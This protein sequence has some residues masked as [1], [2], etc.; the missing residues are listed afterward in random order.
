M[1][2]SQGPRQYAAWPASSH[3]PASLPAPPTPLFHHSDLE[4][5]AR[6]TQDT[7]RELAVKKSSA[8]P[9]FEPDL[10]IED[11]RRSL[12]TVSFS[13]PQKGQDAGLGQQEV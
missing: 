10:H 7:L 2:S 6:R 4:A 13:V 12:G 8:A 11:L 9:C 5:K 3:D 1:K